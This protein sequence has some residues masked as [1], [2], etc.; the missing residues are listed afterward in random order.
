MRHIAKSLLQPISPRFI[1]DA[2]KVVILRWSDADEASIELASKR[3]G[4]VCISQFE[5]VRV[6]RMLHE[7]DLADPWTEAEPSSQSI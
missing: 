4:C 2:I 3:P 5:H 1:D 6:P 7:I